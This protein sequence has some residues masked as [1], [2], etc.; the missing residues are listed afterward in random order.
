MARLEAKAAEPR[1]GQSKS[2]SASDKLGEGRGRGLRA[3]GTG[4]SAMRA[5]GR[6]AGA[7]LAAC[8]AEG[9]T[10]T[11]ASLFQTSQQRG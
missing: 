9:W 4:E 3:T 2:I 1:A 5:T 6:K 10:G 8:G 7:R 11:A